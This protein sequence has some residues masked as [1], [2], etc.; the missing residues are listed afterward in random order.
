MNDILKNICDQ[1][2]IEI[3][4]NKNKCSYSS[5]QKLIKNK[6]NRNFR[7]LVIDSQKKLTNNII[8]EIKKSSPS[9]GLIIKDYYPENIAINYEK[10]GVGALSI[11]TEKNFF[12]GSIDDLSLVSKKTNIPIL[13]KDFII[14]P[15]QILESKIYNADA[16][17]LIA[18]ILNDLEI[19]N[20]INLS[21]KYNL[22]CLIEV[23]NEEEL[24]RI[25]NIG[26]PVIGINNRN[27][28]NLN[29]DSN[30]A[31][32]LISKIPKDFTIIAESGIKSKEDILK[33]NEVGVFNFLIG[34]SILKSSNIT[35]KVKELLN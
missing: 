27:L 8:G 25:L 15:Y 1:K 9:A 24:K 26:Y 14:D 31:L 5:L 34:E 13:R 33:Y 32:N 22:D 7:N 3:E 30:Y 21:K 16:I 2:K 18:T 4:I 20:F 29:V 35:K 6:V 11:L 10:S 17:L 19:K 28:K 12:S 23:H